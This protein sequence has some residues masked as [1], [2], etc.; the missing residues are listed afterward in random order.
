MIFKK[1][2][3]L[4]FILLLFDGKFRRKTKPSQLKRLPNA[5]VHEQ[6]AQPKPDHPN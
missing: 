4:K 6:R 1:A 3:S 2:E 5:E